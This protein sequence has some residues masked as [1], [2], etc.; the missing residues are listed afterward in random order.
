MTLKPIT[1]IQKIWHEILEDTSWGEFSLDYKIQR[2]LFLAFQPGPCYYWLLNI[3]TATFEM[4]SAEAENVL[5]YPADEMTF[6]FLFSTIHPD[7][8]PYLL[9]FEN[10][11]MNF[12]RELPDEKK[13]GY[14]IQYDFRAKHA[15]GTY[16]RLLNQM[17]V[18]QNDI[19]KNHIR[20]FGVHADITHLKKD[21]RPVLSFVALNPEDPSYLDITVENIYKPAKGILSRREKEV[22]GLILEGMI[23]KE[24]CARLHISKFT[25]DSHRKKILEKTSSRSIPEMVKKAIVNGWV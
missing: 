6:Q 12:F 7:D 1:E 24:I 19:D 15:N 13:T 5:G 18:V 9:N 22:L 23:S 11:I 14:K 25:V 2:K 4:L 20:T 10:A 16:I 21:I 3:K 17:T 8:M